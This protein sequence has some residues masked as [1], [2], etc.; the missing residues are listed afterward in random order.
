M[1]CFGSRSP[2]R[3]GLNFTKH[4]WH[5]KC[6]AKPAAIH[7]HTH[8]EEYADD[9]AEAQG[10]YFMIPTSHGTAEWHSITVGLDLS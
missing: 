1:E 4:Q 2:G 10:G 5:A 7:P 6:S 8:P 3:K 9:E